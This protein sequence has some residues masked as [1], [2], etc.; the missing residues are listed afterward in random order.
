MLQSL[1]RLR[2]TEGRPLSPGP[3]I[4]RVDSASSRW[5]FSYGGQYL[6]PRR[7]HGIVR[8]PGLQPGD[9]NPLPHRV[10]EETHRDFL[11]TAPGAVGASMPQEIRPCY[12]PRLQRPLTVQPARIFT[13]SLSMWRERATTS[14]RYRVAPYDAPEVQVRGPTS[15]ISLRSYGV[16]TV[17]TTRA[18]AASCITR[19][20]RPGGAE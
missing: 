3:A 16:A 12:G 9:R 6:C 13:N 11:S 10:P 2:R 17:R 1:L 20:Y 8:N 18:A 4:S 19:I 5:E 14:R 7:R 15:A